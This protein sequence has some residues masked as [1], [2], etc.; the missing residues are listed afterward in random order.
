MPEEATGSK[1]R[2]RE[3][4]RTWVELPRDLVAEVQRYAAGADVNMSNLWYH[5]VV[6]A[7]QLAARRGSAAKLPQ[8]LMHGSQRRMARGSLGPTRAV[9]WRQS[10]AEFERCRDLIDAAG[11]T[12]TAV[13]IAAA[14]AYVDAGGDVVAM[15]WPPNSGRSR[16]A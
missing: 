8:A 1:A 14:Q 9:R 4:H 13:L 3:S 6:Q 7:A 11:S 2:R 10:K 12:V 5:W 16:A 15:S